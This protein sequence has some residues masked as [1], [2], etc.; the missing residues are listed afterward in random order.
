VGNGA[1]GDASGHVASIM[2]GHGSA[3]GWEASAAAPLQEGRRRGE[4]RGRGQEAHMELA[5]VGFDPILSSTLSPSGTGP[6]VLLS[7]GDGSNAP[8]DRMLSLPL[9]LP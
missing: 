8:H 6:G 2:G 7:S 5:T 9:P 3:S 4:G 1:I